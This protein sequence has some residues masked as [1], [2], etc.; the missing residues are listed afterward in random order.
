MGFKAE[1]GT[2]AFVAGNGGRPSDVIAAPTEGGSVWAFAGLP[3]ALPEGAYSL[4]PG[5]DGSP[6]T[7]FALGWALGSYAFTR[8]KKP[9]RRPRPSFGPRRPIEMK[10]SALRKGS[11]WRAT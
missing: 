9:K 11:I 5:N 2:F 7:D 6:L 1:P 4:E 3:M 10:S 8:Y